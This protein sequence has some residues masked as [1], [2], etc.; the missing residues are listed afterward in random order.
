MKSTFFKLYGR[1]FLKAAII[2]TLT[3]IYPIIQDSISAGQLS[4]DWKKIGIAAIGGFLAY[5]A[6][7]FFTDDTKASVNALTSQGATIITK[8]Q[9]VIQPN[10]NIKKTN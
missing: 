3:P 8:D 10:E 9:T 7:N 4:F 1:D 2:A 5:L 6:K